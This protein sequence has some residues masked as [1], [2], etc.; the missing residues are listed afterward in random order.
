[1]EKTILNNEEM[2]NLFENFNV[3][4]LKNFKKMF[5][6]VYDYD[7][8]DAE[9]IINRIV[10]S[11]DVL[12]IPNEETFSINKLNTKELNFLYDIALSAESCLSTIQYVDVEKDKEITTNLIKSILNEMSNRNT[13]AKVKKLE[14]K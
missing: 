8:K 12:L 13:E 10:N 11:K 9:K 5:K 7:M 6:Y 14:Y 1:M 4:E 3:L 2:E